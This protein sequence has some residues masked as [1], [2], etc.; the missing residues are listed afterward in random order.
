MGCLFC[1][2]AL[3]LQLLLLSVALC[4]LCLSTLLPPCPGHYYGTAVLQSA[5]AVDNSCSYCHIFSK[6]SCGRICC[7]VCLR[8]A[9]AT[10]VRHRMVGRRCCMQHVRCGRKKRSPCLLLMTDM[11]VKQRPAA[12]AG[13]SAQRG[14]AALWLCTVCRSCCTTWQRCIVAVHCALFSLDLVR[15]A[16]RPA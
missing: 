3:L 7:M 6:G 8:T 13:A 1:V 10:G 11:A 2:I 12:T 9:P 15:A 16:Q 4:D 14:S 5:H